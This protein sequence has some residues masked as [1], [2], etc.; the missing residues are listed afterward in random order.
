MFFISCD[1]WRVK[2]FVKIY[3]YLEV[4]F[5]HHVLAFWERRY[6]K[7]AC[8][9]FYLKNNSVM[10]EP[11]FQNE[12]LVHHEVLISGPI[13]ESKG[14]HAIFQKKGKKCTKFE[15]ILKKGR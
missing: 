5:N 13:L 8:I 14:M 6:L 7:E 11:K 3:R 1:K 2:F 12:P 15:N 4:L 9:F 10:L